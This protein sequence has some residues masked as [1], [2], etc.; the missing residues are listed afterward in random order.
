M[1]CENLIYFTNLSKEEFS[2]DEV[3]ELYSKRWDIEVSYKTMKTTQEIERH[4]SLNGDVARNDIYA[5]VLFH[6]IV[7]V[8]R[9]EINHELEKRQ[10]E[11]NMS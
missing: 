3:I 10:T 7:G 2:A 5:K 4:I 1:H 6:N 9:K 11:K 8:L